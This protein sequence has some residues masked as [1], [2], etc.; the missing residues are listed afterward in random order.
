MIYIKL[1]WR[2]LFRNKRR[3]FIAGTAIGLGLAALIF[4]DAMI[5]GMLDNYIHNATSS[6]MGEAQILN[7]NFREIQEVEFTINEFERVIDGLKNDPSVDKFAPR[8]SAFGTISSASSMSGIGL[9]GVDPENEKYL[10]IIDEA[11]FEGE[12]FEGDNP[13][14]ILI[15]KK[16][17]E[18]LSVGLGDRV[19][20][21]NSRAGSGDIVQD[22][23]RVSGIFELGE[24]AMDGG[25]A[26]I[27]LD[28][29][30]EI[31]GLG[32]TAHIIAIKFTDP[33]FSQNKD[34]PFWS[35][36]STDGNEAISWK[37]IFPQLVSV[38]QM[39]D[40]S[41]GIMS[42]ILMGVVVFVI[43]NTLFMSLYERMFEFGVIKALGTRPFAILRL[44]IF[45]AAALSIISIVIGAIIG[46]L[47]TKTVAAIGIDY[48]GMEMMGLTIRDKIRPVLTL[49][50]F[51]IYPIGVFLFTIIVGI[52]PAVSAARMNPA[53]AMRKSV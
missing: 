36:F 10:S 40:L 19:I 48:S 16:L 20:I 9:F 50:Q 42:F 44:M 31:F 24:R 25:A 2:N 53:N 6:F 21:T 37:E 8:I 39:S 1:A 46:I 32:R 45:E 7:E 26:F 52:F 28:K 49:Q 30:R 5:I 23:F 41:R 51:I 34:L 3:T 15:G 38:F 17:A 22:L 29:A 35:K 4:T 18:I 47:L 14:D 13:R 27:R 33:K 12:Y 11:V 43:L